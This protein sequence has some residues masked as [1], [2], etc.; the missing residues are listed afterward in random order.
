MSA[1]AGT[2]HSHAIQQPDS[3]APSYEPFRRSS[4]DPESC[5]S[6]SRLANGRY[7]CISPLDSDLALLAALVL[8]LF[9][10][11]APLVVS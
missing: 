7:G 3:C 4:A 6:L 11:R 1:H 9:Q 2:C 10:A 5:R 8:R